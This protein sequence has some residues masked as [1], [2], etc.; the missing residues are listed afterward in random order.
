MKI[1]V[2]IVDNKIPKI[3]KVLN[4]VSANTLYWLFR[5]HILDDEKDLII[6]GHNTDT[7]NIPYDED[8]FSRCYQAYKHFHWDS[9]DAE[10]GVLKAQH[11]KLKPVLIE[12]VKNFMKLCELYESD[13]KTWLV[14][15]KKIMGDN[16]FWA[17]R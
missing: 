12:F 6:A 15:I 10:L 17:S 11:Y 9:D 3:A 13:R 4:G 8:D 1:Q 7:P 2:E 14:E 5:R 16:G